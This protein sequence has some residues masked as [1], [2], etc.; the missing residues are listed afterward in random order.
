MKSTQEQLAAFISSGPRNLWLED[1]LMKVYV[2]KSIR[3]CRNNAMTCL[4][5]AS[6]EVVEEHRS[7]GHFTAFIAH[8]EKV[9]PFSLMLLECVLNPRLAIWAKRNGWTPYR[10]N[11]F[12]KEKHEQT[13]KV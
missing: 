1:G 12:L 7:K 8:A 5:I 2:R 11:S 10:E 9:N 4:D 13:S 3:L 6:I